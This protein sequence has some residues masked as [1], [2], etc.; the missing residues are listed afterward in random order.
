MHGVAC[1]FQKFDGKGKH[2]TS[3]RILSHTAICLR[4]HVKGNNR[5][6]GNLYPEIGRLKVSH[7]HIA[8]SVILIP[9]FYRNAYHIP[10]NVRFDPETRIRATCDIVTDEFLLTRV[11][12]RPL[13]SLHG[14][15][16]RC[17]SMPRVLSSSSGHAACHSITT[18]PAQQG[19]KICSEY[20]TSQHGSKV[21][22]V[23]LQTLEEANVASNNGMAEIRNSI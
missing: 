12:R 8:T 15:L 7:M 19:C 18:A 10:I 2:Q 21:L 6:C 3:T 5:C 17:W 23:C 22:C 9:S 4:N 1:A 11:R 13:P 20:F 16:A 14:A